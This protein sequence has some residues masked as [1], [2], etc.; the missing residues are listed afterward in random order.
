[1]G[2]AACNG[3]ACKPTEGLLNAVTISLAAALGF[4]CTAFATASPELPPP[5]T[6]RLVGDKG[7][8]RQL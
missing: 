3:T 1:M 7:D 2:S 8:L 4:D 6:E 5:G